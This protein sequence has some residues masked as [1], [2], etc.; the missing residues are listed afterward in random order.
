MPVSIL[1]Q[2]KLMS[3]PSCIFYLK[4]GK[5]AD[6]YQKSS[7]VKDMLILDNC[8]EWVYLMHDMTRTTYYMK[9]ITYIFINKNKSHPL[10]YSRNYWSF[11]FLGWVFLNTV[12]YIFVHISSK[13]LN[14]NFYFML[15]HSLENS[16]M[17]N[18][19]NFTCLYLCIASGCTF[20]ISIRINKDGKGYTINRLCLEHKGHPVGPRIKPLYPSV[21]KPDLEATKSA[22]TM[23]ACGA[24][25]V[26]V[27]NFLHN[28]GFAVK[29]KDVYNL[30]Q[31]ITQGR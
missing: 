27:Q 9:T 7:K 23:L 4:K 2:V 18:T 10:F 15:P 11:Q 24:A 12:I 8:F 16:L 1:S 13:L 31:K 29:S 6:Y 22:S 17:S 20:F 30:T 25:P 26:L 14:T 21:R 19:F 28:K 3:A 5:K